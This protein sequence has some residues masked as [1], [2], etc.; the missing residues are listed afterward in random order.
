MHSHP[1]DVHVL[2]TEINKNSKNAVGV[3]A[4]KKHRFAILTKKRSV[5][6]H[7]QKRGREQSSLNGALING[8]A[9]SRLMVKEGLMEW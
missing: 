2:L 4:Y 1:K 6:L 3:A 9:A 8:E 7:S 5:A